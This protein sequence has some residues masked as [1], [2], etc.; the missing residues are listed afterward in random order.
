MKVGVPEANVDATVVFSKKRAALPGFVLLVKITFQ[1]TS[2]SLAQSISVVNDAV[3]SDEVKQ[4]FAGRGITYDPT[5]VSVAGNVADSITD[6]SSAS[7]LG[8]AASLVGA[9]ILLA[10]L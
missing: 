8:F 4:V 2:M 6:P 10:A 5:S 7:R 1:D 9:L 3:N